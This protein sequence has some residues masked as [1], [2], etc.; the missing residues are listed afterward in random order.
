M[1]VFLGA[2]VGRLPCVACYLFFLTSAAR[3]SVVA[4]VVGDQDTATLRKMNS[5]SESEAGEGGAAGAEHGPRGGPEAK[6]D[7][8]YCRVLGQRHQ[9]PAAQ[10]HDRGLDV[11]HVELPVIQAI[12]SHADTY[13]VAIHV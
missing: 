13:T 11:L 7:E 6:R 1:F 9:L 5:S 2:L 8:R 10:T 4:F 12:T 3:T